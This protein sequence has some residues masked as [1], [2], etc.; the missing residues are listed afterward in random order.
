MNKIFRYKKFILLLFTVLNGTS[1]TST[2]KTIILTIF[3]DLLGII[4]WLKSFVI[5]IRRVFIY[6]FA[7]GNNDVARSHLTYILTQKWN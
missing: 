4:L 7:I 3:S 1:T 5:T 2:H 6:V